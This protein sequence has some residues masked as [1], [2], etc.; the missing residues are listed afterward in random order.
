M[1]LIWSIEHRAWWRPNHLGYT[2][3]IEQAGMYSRDDA[4]AVVDGAT[5]QWSKTVP[6]ELPVRIEDLP[7]AAKVLLGQL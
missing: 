6:N 2:Q 3:H 1:F 4:M 5:F 7:D